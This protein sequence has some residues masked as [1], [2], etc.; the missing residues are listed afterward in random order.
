MDKSIV[1]GFFGPP[2]TCIGLGNVHRKVK[3][4]RVVL[5]V[6]LYVQTDRQTNRHRRS[7]QDYDLLPMTE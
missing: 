7:T 2:C 6:G 1:C 5:D 3:F 4:E